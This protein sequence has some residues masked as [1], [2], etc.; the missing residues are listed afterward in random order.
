MRRCISPDGRL[1]STVARKAHFARM[2]LTA[3]LSCARWPEAEDIKIYVHEHPRRR[4]GGAGLRR[5]PGGGVL[6][7]GSRSPG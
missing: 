7:Q 3:Y 2:T 6:R 4:I 1:T 5:D